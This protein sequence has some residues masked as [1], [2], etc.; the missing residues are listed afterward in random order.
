MKRDLRG[1]KL[2]REVEELYSVLRRPGSGQISDA[3]DID[4]SPD[5]NTIAFTGSIVDD[6]VGA[7]S[8][9][10][11]LFDVGSADLRVATF[12]RNND[13]SPK[14]SIAGNAVAFLS[15]RRSVGNF[16]LFLLDIP[17]GSARAAP[18]VNGWVEYLQ[19]SPDGKRILL[20]VAAHG[21]DVSGG[22]GAIKSN[23]KEEAVPSWTP[24]IDRGEEDIPRRSVWIYDCAANDLFPVGGNEL[25]VWEA[26]WCGSQRIAVVASKG[27]GEG[28]WYEAPLHI[29]EESGQSTGA[30]Y[31][32]KSQLGWP[33]ATPSGGRV[34]FVEAISSDRWLV[35]GDL[36]I[37]DTDSRKTRFV[38][39][40]GVDVT[41]TEWRSESKLLVA[42]HRG[43]ETVVGIYDDVN[44]VFSETWS[45]TDITTAG[46]YVRVTGIEDGGDCALIGESFTV[47]PEI[48]IIHDGKYQALR[49][50]D[51]NYSK[52]VAAVGGVDKIVWSAPDGLEIQGWLLKPKG[53]SPYALI[54]SVH[55]GPVWH[56]RPTWLGRVSAAYLIMVRHGYAVFFPN[57]RG[58]SG[59]GQEFA[60]QV[61]GDMGGLDTYD[62]LS[63]LDYLVD[64]GIAD[65]KRL[66]VTGGSYGGFMTAWLV[67]KDSRFAAAVPSSPVT[68]QMTQHLL[69]NIPRFVQLFIGDKY[70][71]ASG[72]YLQR[73]PIMFAAKVTTPVL[74]IAGSLDR[75]T[76]PQEAVQFHN[77]LLE[78]GKVSVLAIYPEEGHGIRKWPAVI[79][80][81]ARVV[82]WFEKYM[83]AQGKSPGDNS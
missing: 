7:P 46:R 71:N 16:Q 63:G 75:C 22:Q 8:T 25:N 69:S 29:L 76:P 15:D 73:S 21:A 60:R 34:A 2:F 3:A 62:Y 55:G 1:T 30:V 68:N 72:K 44:G 12:G 42:G 53:P 49:S 83:P 80:Y 39:T 6:F 50:L 10:I 54:M 5:G 43:F 41:F 18:E 36:R 33:S 79:D 45:S 28:H 14:F 17:T 59:R 82:D 38:D 19:W 61:F 13:R 47:A 77:A 78:E 35:A 9:R 4:I 56:W 67:T 66:G 70:S 37:L 74:N 81:I 27:A 24:K 65:P 40:K 48:A 11:C 64:S 23:A 51:Q 32:G 52:Q 57:P 31:V 20:G 58:S 26:A